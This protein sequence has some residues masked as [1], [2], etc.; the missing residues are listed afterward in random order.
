MAAAPFALR[1]PGG[2]GPVRAR[3]APA[4]RA[5]AGGVRLGGRHPEGGQEAQ[6]VRAQQLDTGLEI[7]AY[8]RNRSIIHDWHRSMQVFPMLPCTLRHFYL[9][10]NLLQDHVERLFGK[11]QV[12]EKNR[13]QRFCMKVYEKII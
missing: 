6:P 10:G 2:A 3:G 9:R 12:W 13:G 7:L 5:G 1:V 4:V 8:G 11:V